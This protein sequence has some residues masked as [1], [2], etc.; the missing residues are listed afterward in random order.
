M[1][2]I[3]IFRLNEM[4]WWAGES[5]EDCVT[6]AMDLSG[7]CK[8]ELLE[9]FE[10]GEV[11]AEGMEKLTF[12]EDDEAETKKTF[13]QKL[14]EMIAAGEKFPCCFAVTEY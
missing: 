14:D 7:L 10:Q 13:R 4:E 3:K 9:D 1:G 5:M 2:E 11:S 8:E 6:A 12:V